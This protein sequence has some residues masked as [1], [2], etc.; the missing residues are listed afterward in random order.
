MAP[1]GTRRDNPQQPKI[2]GERVGKPHPAI[3]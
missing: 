2:G 1:D 3:I